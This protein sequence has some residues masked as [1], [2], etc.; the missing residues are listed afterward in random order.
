M[1]YIN[2]D[3]LEI[4]TNQNENNATSNEG[5]R[6]TLMSYKYIKYPL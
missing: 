1:S 3:L 6:G 4:S 5:G 2:Y